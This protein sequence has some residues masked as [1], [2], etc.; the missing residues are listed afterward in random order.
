M[1]L[2][3]NKEGIQTSAL[4]SHSHLLVASHDPNEEVTSLSVVTF[5][6]GEPPGT[7]NKSPPR[8]RKLRSKTLWKPSGQSTLPEGPHIIT[9]LP[10]AHDTVL[11]GLGEHHAKPPDCYGIDGRSLD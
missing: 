11:L 1:T 2:T 5:P 9:V 3:L 7:I 8:N 6:V 10:L 4:L